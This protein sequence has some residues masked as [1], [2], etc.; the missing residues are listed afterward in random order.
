MKSVIW[1]PLRTPDYRRLWLAQCVSIVGDKVNQIALSIMVYRLTGSLLQMGAMLAVTVLPSAMFGLN[2]GSLI[3]RWD[4]RRTMFFADIFRACLVVAIPPLAH[5]GLPAIYTLAFLVATVSLFFEPARLS[6]VPE[7]VSPADLMAAN[8][9]DN[10]TNA[11]AELLGIALGG[12]LVAV[13]GYR[14]AFFLD[15][16]TYAVS[17]LLIVSLAY[18]RKVREVPR[19]GIGQLR[20]D[21]REGVRRIVGQP[22]LR[23]L[24]GVYTLAALGASAAI[25]LCFLIAL[26]EFRFAGMPDAVRLAVVDT[27]IT[28]GLVLGGLL[29]GMSGSGRAGAKFLWGLMVFGGVFAAVAL[30]GDFWLAVALLFCAGVANVWFQIPMV[31]LIQQAT[32]DEYRGRVFALRT[33]VVRIVTVVGLLGAGAL[34]QALGVAPAVA[35]VGGFVFIVGV[36]GWTRRALREA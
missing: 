25:T 36:A 35:V 16:A 15:A 3:D 4:R 22:V 2:A 14:S 9:L 33:V 34:A 12:T 6:L 32:E 10:T 18:R 26:K 21:L 23:D 17:A 30:V 13:I 8:S 29:L 24:V 7:V 31:T 1:A 11:V 28:G 27:A 19:F 20:A 5:F